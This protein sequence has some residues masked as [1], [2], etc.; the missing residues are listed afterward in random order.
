MIGEWNSVIGTDKANTFIA[1]YTYQ[2]ES[3]ASRGEFFPMVDILE[4]GITYTTF[5]FEPFTPNNELRYKTF[6]VQD[7]FTW[8]RGSHALMFGVSAERYESENVFFP[9]SQSVYIYNSLADFYTDANDY[10][11]NPNRTTSPVTL[12]RFQVR[13]MN[14]PGLDKPIAAARGLVHGALRPGRVAG[15]S[16]HQ[17]HLRPALRRPGLRRHRASR[18]PPP[19]RSPSATRTATRSSTRPPS[20]RTPTSCGR[21]AS[22]STGTW[23]AAATRRC[24]A[25]PASS[26]AS[27]PTSGSRTR[28]ATPACSPASSSST[29]H[30][31]G[32]GTPAPPRTSQRT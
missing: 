1:G 18:T 29:T 20:C 17:G 4:G 22:A 21:R 15:H 5:G 12:R 3:R 11:A 2:D 9:G 23:T 16:A 10:L 6:Q 30:A 25:A 7:N 13:W 24:A 28:S 14:I 26:P 27:R 31:C 32:R 19:T 8:N